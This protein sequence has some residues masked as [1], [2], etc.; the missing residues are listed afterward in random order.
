MRS[1]VIIR[2]RGEGYTSNV[3]G[4]FGGGHTGARCGLTPF[5]AAAHAAQL[6][7]RYSQSNP[8]GGDL[9]APPEILELV[10]E[11]LRSIAAKTEDYFPCHH[12]DGSGKILD[13]NHVETAEL[14][15]YCDGT[16]QASDE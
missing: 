16:G 13:E 10:P 11:H 8:E 5:D 12:C 2:K 1:T 4:K 6:M 14:C 3:T 15:S 9:M 7:I